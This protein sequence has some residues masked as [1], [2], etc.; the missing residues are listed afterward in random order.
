[1][2]FLSVFFCWMLALS[3]A[4]QDHITHFCGQTEAR[5]RLFAKHSH[6]REVCE[7]D[8]RELERFTQEQENQRGGGTQVYIIPVVFHVIHLNGPENISTEQIMDAINVLNRDFRKLNSDTIAIVDEF[9]DIAADSYIEFRLATIDPEGNC[10]SGINRIVS[11]LTNDGYNSDIKLLSNWPRNSY[12]N[13]WVC[14]EIGNNIAGF[15]YLPG[16]VNGNWGT[17]EDGIVMRSDYIGTIGTGAI[18]RSRTLTHEVGHWL[19]LYHTWGPTNSPGDASNCDFDDNVADTPNTIGYTSCNLNGASCGSAIDNVQNYMEYSYCSRMFTQGQANR[20]RAALQSNTAQRNQLW[21]SANL[22]ETG[23]LNPPLCAASF[24]SSQYTV[25]AGDEVAFFDDSYHNVVSWNWDFGDGQTFGGND[26]LIHKNPSHAYAEPGIYSVTLTVSNGVQS[27]SATETA[28]VRVL[29]SAMMQSPFSEGFEGTWPGLWISN[30]I[31]GDEAWETTTAASYSG[32]KSLRLRNFNIDAG[33]VDELYSATIDLTGA[34]MATISYKWAWANRST[35]TDDRL[36]LSA[37]GDCGLSWS[38]R[39]M[40]KGSTNLPTVD[41]TDAFFIP[42]GVDQWS[43]TSVEL[44]NDEW[45][46]DRFRFKFDFTSYGGNNLYLDDINVVGQFASGVREVTPLFIYS[47]YPNPTEGNMT[48]DI[49]Q[50][51]SEP[52]QILLVNSLG[53]AV[54]EIFN[55]VLSSGKHLMEIEEQ[56]AGL[57]TLVLSKGTHSDIRRVVFK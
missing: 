18:T 39:K 3:A 23:V 7:H 49:Q 52:V 26:P 32:T 2:K 51:A 41:P 40:H 13:V 36:R 33:N 6:S 37:S 46:N 9:V 31:N 45:F 8:T 28:F 24:T 35:E 14:A 12:L 56:A 29:S 1:M 16:D 25:C 22:A 53:Q 15:T 54:K 34:E 55:G 50:L 42:S 5:E 43:Q 47:V 57:Y 38:M 17:L 30:N 48:L 11:D 21:T 4:A 44:I 19:N 10:S 27:V 20:M